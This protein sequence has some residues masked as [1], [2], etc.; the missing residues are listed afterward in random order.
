MMQTHLT[1]NTGKIAPLIAPL[2]DDMGYDLVRV[3]LQNT[4]RPVL[5]IMIERQDGDNI[6]IDD[7]SEASH[8]I[9]AALDVEDPIQGAWNLELSSAGIDRPLTRPSDF[10]DWKGFEAKIETNI[11]VNG[12][13]KFHGLLNGE[14]EGVISITPSNEPDA[15]EISFQDIHK[16]K[17]VLTDALLEA[18][19]KGEIAC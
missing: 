18:A 15:V 2:L 7:C 8:A 11:P 4:K 19:E 5:Q 16:A 17:L 12:S 3:Q 6:S 10:N 9:S 14:N 1:D 13:R